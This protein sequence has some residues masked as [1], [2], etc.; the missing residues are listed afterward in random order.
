M[1]KILTILLLSSLICSLAACGKPAG[2][3]STE[4][5]ASSTESASD[6]GTSPVDGT[7]SQ[8]TGADASQETLGQTLLAD[9]KG[10]MEKGG[11]SGSALA[12]A[13]AISQNPVIPFD[14]VAMEAEEGY[15]AGF[16][17][18]IS[19]FSQ[20]ASFAPMISSIPFVGY[21]F[22]L[23][24]DADVDAFVENLKNLADPGWNICTQAD[25]TIAEA[26]GRTVF[27]LM[28]PAS[29]QE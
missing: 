11:D 10:R 2:D 13:E 19:G 17:E 21:I 7:E 9:F 15:L 26:S 14:P 22:V 16:T 4:K 1:K 18:E 6:S 27:F 8:S 25:E 20:G 5:T 24:E 3:A 29:A 12:L 28:C 23:E